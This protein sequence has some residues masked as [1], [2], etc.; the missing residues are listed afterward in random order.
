MKVFSFRLSYAF[1]L[2]GFLL[3][4]VSDCV[5]PHVGMKLNSVILTVL[6]HE[7]GLYVKDSAISQANIPKKCEY[8]KRESTIFIFQKREDYRYQTCMAAGA[9]QRCICGM[10]PKSNGS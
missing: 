8:T 4:S 9:G 3:L 1:I 2:L 10:D 6:L 7:K 5:N